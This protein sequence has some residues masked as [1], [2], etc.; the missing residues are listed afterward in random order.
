MLD[1]LGLTRGLILTASGKVKDAGDWITVHCVAFSCDTN[2]T[3]IRFRN[4]ELVTDP[5]VFEIVA[6][7][8]VGEEPVWAYIGRRFENGLYV[9]FNGAGVAHV[10]LTVEG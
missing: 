4:G 5:I 6:D 2:L 9:E 7:S 8:A 3:S 1:F 10:N